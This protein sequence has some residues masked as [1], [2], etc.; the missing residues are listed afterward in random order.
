LPGL[1]AAAAK[2]RTQEL[3]ELVELEEAADR[4]IKGSPAA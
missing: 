3:L 4:V 1:D 2:A